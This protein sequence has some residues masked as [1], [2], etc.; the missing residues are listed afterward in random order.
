MKK[1]YVFSASLLLCFEIFS[2]S[3]QVGITSKTYTDVNRNNRQVKAEIYY[4]AL[5][6]GNNTS[7]ANGKFP[8]IVFGH[9]FVM[10]YTAYENLSSE[11]VPK[12]YILV[13]AN[14]ETGFSPNHEEFGK[15]LIFLVNSFL[16]DNS[17][18]AF[19]LYNK[20]DSAS[21]IMG[22][23]MGGGCSI[24][25]AANNNSI[26]TVIGFA[27]AETNPSAI[28]AAANVTVPALILSGE[29]DGV[30]PPAQ[31]HLPIYNALASVCKTFITIK[32]GAH[33]YFAKPNFN[34][35][36]G[37][38]TSS[39][40]ISITRQEQQQVTYD[41]VGLWLNYFLKND[42]NSFTAFLDSLQQSNR[43]TYQ[44][45]CV[46][47]NAAEEDYLQKMEFEIFPNP[48][49]DYLSVTSNEFPYNLQIVSADGRLT[50][51]KK[52]LEHS[53][54]FDLSVF[55]DGFYIVSFQYENIVLHKKLFIVRNSN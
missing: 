45:S 8:F 50:W 23:S 6:A 1:Y 20:I 7:P 5:S 35:D 11:W 2:Q 55:P 26:K 51:H 43:I 49:S 48:A 41:F 27:P 10:T 33:C 12:G 24:L 38:T 40:G 46:I 37:E 4:P 25:A 44:N 28:T 9:G 53:Q 19:I 47:P 54:H 22:H 18:N 39:P 17:N 32:G 30:T 29:K 42:A 34:C 21:A 3:F 15:D 13:F 36:F 52:I 14:T 31:H 16:L